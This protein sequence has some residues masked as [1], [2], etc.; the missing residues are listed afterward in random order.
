[1]S[2][3]FLIYNNYYYCNL[4]HHFVALQ[5]CLLLKCQVTILYVY[6]VFMQQYVQYAHC[7]LFYAA[8]CS[9]CTLYSLLCSNM[10]SMHTVFSFMQIKVREISLEVEGVMVRVV[11]VVMLVDWIQVAGMLGS[12]QAVERQMMFV[13]IGEH[14]V[15]VMM[16]TIITWI[17]RIAERNRIIG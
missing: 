8:I 2:N 12:E 7:I 3:F 14:F 11:C 16:K 1:M 17:I 15:Q 10:F 5:V 6:A 4:A 13:G 9:V